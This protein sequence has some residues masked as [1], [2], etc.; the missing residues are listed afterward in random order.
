MSRGRCGSCQRRTPSASASSASAREPLRLRHRARRLDAVEAERP[1][2]HGLVAA[3][4]DVVDDRGDDRSCEHPLDGHEQDRRRAGRLEPRQ[5]PPDVRRRH[6]RVHG[7]HAR[8]GEREHAR[9]ARAGDERAD[10][11]E[12]APRARSASGSGCARVDDAAQDRRRAGSGA[13]PSSRADEHRLGG[14]ERA[15]RAQ[16]VRAQRVAARDEVDDRVGEPE[17]RRDLDRARD[18]DE[19]DRRR[20][21]RRAARARAAGR[22]SRRARRRGRRA[23]RT[24]TPPARRPRACSAPKPSRSSSVDLA[25]RSRTRSAPVM[26]Q[27]TTP[28]CTYSGTSAARTSSTSTGAFRHGNASARS[29]G[30]SGP[31]PASSSSATAGSRSRPLAGTA[32]VRRSALRR[33]R[34]S[35]ASR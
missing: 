34:R 24:A 33:F 32:I 15:E 2:A 21:A 31:R 26:P 11:V 29:P 12:R 9:R 8:L 17:P 28:S 19:L 30:C 22:R 4:A 27:S 16:A 13:S 18:L 3:R 1:L 25:P 23:S 35:S 10:L 6:E 20:R 5:Q 7:D 14:E